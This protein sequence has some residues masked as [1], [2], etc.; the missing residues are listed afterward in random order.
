MNKFIISN[1][2]K[3]NVPVSFRHYTG[4]ADT[5]I[6]FFEY[7]NT[8]EEYADDEAIVTGRYYQ[9]DIWSKTNY[10]KLVKDVEKML[11]EMKFR[12]RSH[13]DAPYEKD[14]GLYHKVLRYYY[15]EAL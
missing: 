6:T 15:E 7:I 11:K 3:L 5:Y 12:K 13:N 2:S 4:S 1:L 9:F 8:D 10:S 14:T